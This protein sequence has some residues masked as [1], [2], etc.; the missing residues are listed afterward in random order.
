[1]DSSDG[2]NLEFDT[3]LVENKNAGEIF[4]F[5][6][7]GASAKHLEIITDV[8]RDGDGFLFLDTNNQFCSYEITRANLIKINKTFRAENFNISWNLSGGLFNII[9]TKGFLEFG[10]EFQVLVFFNS[11]WRV[12][13]SINQP[14]AEFTY[15]PSD[16]EIN[17]TI[18]FDGSESYYTEPITRYDWKWDSTDE[19]HNDLGAY[20]THSYSQNGSYKVTLR[21]WSGLERNSCLKIVEVG[22]SQ[23]NMNFVYENEPLFEGYPLEI[24][25][26][27][28]ENNN[29][30]TTNELVIYR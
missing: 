27:D 18:Q 21:V 25:K 7:K 5:K 14:A 15:S 19:W 24:L 30:S 17:E 20:P 1:M 8:N 29:S 23:G 22:E 28:T 12:L 6:S 2:F 4:T 26:D 16:P 9:D 11:K 13:I 3:F 10:A